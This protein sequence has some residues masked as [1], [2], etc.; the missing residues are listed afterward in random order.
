VKLA[1][2]L[3]KTVDPLDDSLGINLNTPS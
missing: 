1:M 3:G 2:T